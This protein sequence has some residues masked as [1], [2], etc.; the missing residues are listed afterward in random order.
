MR[1]NWTNRRVKLPQ[2]LYGRTLHLTLHRKVMVMVINDSHTFCSMSIN[3][4]IPEKN[5]FRKIDLDNPRSRSCVRSKVKV[6]LLAQKSIDLLNF[7]FTFIPAIPEVQLLKKMTMK[8]WGEDHGQGQIWLL[9]LSPSVQLM[10]L[11]FISWQSAFFRWDIAN[12]I[13][14]LEN[15][16]SSSWPKSNKI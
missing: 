10:R 6:T 9:Y 16:W 8:I 14:D 4:L 12:S 11:L 2:S 3:P 5:L 15:S 1:Y 7:R 13:V